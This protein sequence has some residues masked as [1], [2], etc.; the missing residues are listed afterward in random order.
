M[1]VT[2]FTALAVRIFTECSHIYPY[3]TRTRLNTDADGPVPHVGVARL[4]HGVIVHVD[5]FVQVARDHDRD[6]LQQSEVELAGDGVHEHVQSDG[7]EVANRDL[8]G[9]RVLDDLCEERG[10]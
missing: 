3:T 5:D 7:R 9:G 4:D 10:D 1:I 8:V 6:V 2:R